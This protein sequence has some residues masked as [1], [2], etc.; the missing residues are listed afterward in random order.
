M[1]AFV[2]LPV[3]EGWIGPMMRAQ[4][5]LPGGRTVEADDLH[6]TLAF[7]DDQPEAR[8]EAL[9][10]ELDS[11]PLPRA[12]LIP[13]TWALLGADRPRAAGLDLSADAGLVALRDQVRGA[14]RRAGIDL[15]RDRFRPHVTLARFG[16]TAPADMT[17]LPGALARLGPPE[18]AAAPAGA[19]I[20]WSSVL[21]PQGPQY[22]T[23]AS[24]PLGAA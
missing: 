14:A 13:M 21:T 5:R 2:G 15:P 18:V 7:L 11:R 6:V 8:L 1:R 12:T 20:L 4:A 16:A 3:P 19:A 17:R 10:E 24:Y 9:H 22:D 23:L